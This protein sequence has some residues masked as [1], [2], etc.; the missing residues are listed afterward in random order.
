[1]STEHQQYSTDNQLAAIAQ[2]A[3]KRGFEVVRSYADEGKSGLR[4]EGRDALQNLLNDIE[5]GKHDFEHVLVY[6]VSRWGRFQDPDESATY[7]MRCRRAGVK[8]H[9]CAEQFENDGSPVSNIIK[10]IKR[11]MA[12]EYS[13]ELSVKVHAGQ[14]RLIERGFRQGGPAGY[15]LRRVLIDEKG[16]RKQQLEVGERKSIQTDRIILCPG[17]TEE[18]STVN[19]IYRQFVNNGL[20]E[21]AIADQLN[22]KGI[23]R[24]SGELWTRGTVHQILINEKYIGD[25]VWNR[26]SAKLKGRKIR[27]DPS[28]WIRASAVFEPVVDRE[29]FDRARSIIE[30]RS[31]ALTDEEM[32]KAL[33]PL[34]KKYGYLSALIIDE[35]EDCPSSRCYMKRFGSLIRTY[36]LV[37]FNPARDY[38][39]LEINRRLRELHPSIVTAVIQQ[40]HDCGAKVE[41]DSAL[42]LIWVNQEFSVSLVLCRCLI[43]PSGSRRWKIRFDMTLLPDIT[44]AV[45]M[46]D[47]N[48]S[49]H[50]YY[51]FPSIDLSALSIRLSEQN[52]SGLDIYRF[53]NLRPLFDMSRRLS[54]KE[55]AS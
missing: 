20:N 26:V 8:V 32:L 44:V 40:I 42:Q 28:S 45:R 19:W 3:Q 30:K 31:Q 10:S 13:R 2:Y 18:V 34:L 46:A 47:D 55:L 5:R 6:D 41:L 1:M 36:T 22:V 24:G 38:S 48:K 17:P 49:I 7:E 35:A 33:N 9:Y 51:I 11:M 4:L 12:G 16:N 23:Y 25:N 53:D 21:Q 52:A 43:L 50:D 39:Y 29:L 27:N 37:G 15:G 14:S 54:F